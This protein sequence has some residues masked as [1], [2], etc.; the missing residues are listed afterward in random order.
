MRMSSIGACLCSFKEKYALFDYGFICC[1][2][3]VCCILTVTV[4][5]KDKEMLFFTV[6]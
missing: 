6:L 5:S 2:R 4:F 3:E 1:K